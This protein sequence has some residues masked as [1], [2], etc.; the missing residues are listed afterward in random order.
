VRKLSVPRPNNWRIAFAGLVSVGLQTLVWTW[1]RR[2]PAAPAAS[3][4]RDRVEEASWES[5][6]SS[7]PPG[8]IPDHV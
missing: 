3:P 4:I 8:W 6:P 1:H 7:D 2:R 5:F